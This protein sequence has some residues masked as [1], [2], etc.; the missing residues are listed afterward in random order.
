MLA[1][2]LADLTIERDIVQAAFNQLRS[3]HSVVQLAAAAGQAA[4]G[5]L[6][7]EKEQL[8]SQLELLATQKVSRRNNLKRRYWAG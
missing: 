4:A 7:A 3:E 6:S 2:L 5:Q 8:V 1:A